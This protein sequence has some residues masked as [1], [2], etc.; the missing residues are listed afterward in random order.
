[1]IILT[2]ETA[3]TCSA[4]NHGLSVNRNKSLILQGFKLFDMQFLLLAYD[5][6]DSEALRRRMNVREDH[7]KKISGLKK[8]R[9]VSFW[10]RNPR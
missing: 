4:N 7:L 10:R 3:P 9:G 1:M 5:G 6:T 2:F 8:S